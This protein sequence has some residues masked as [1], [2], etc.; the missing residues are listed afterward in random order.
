VALALWLVLGLCIVGSLAL[1][2]RSERNWPISNLDVAALACAIIVG[3]SFLVSPEF[4]PHYGGFLAPF[5]A[6][7]FSATAVRLLP[8]ARTFM[9]IL[10]T[11]VM[12]VFI[13]HSVRNVVDEA[14]VAGPNAAL[15]AAFSP[16]ACVISPVN[17]PVIL[18]NRYNLYESNCPHIVDLFGTE[19]TDGGGVAGVPA[20]GQDPKLQSDWLEWLHHAD[21]LVLEAPLS[22]Y[23]DIG[24][25]A[26]A[27]VRSNFS[28][29]A[30]SGGLYIYRRVPPN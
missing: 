18:A 23:S 29:V 24:A 8:L 13:G 12:V 9:P 3:A 21:G 22:Q 28:L 10:I 30:K 14:Q 25:A 27:E 11:A 2:R 4:D 7:V 6:L 15:A 17:G 20:D 16:K 19:L 5:L 1:A 26:K